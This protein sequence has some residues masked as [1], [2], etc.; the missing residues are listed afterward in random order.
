MLADRAADRKVTYGQPSISS[1]PERVTSDHALHGCIVQDQLYTL[2]KHVL[3]GIGH[4][5]NDW[6]LL[7]SPDN[8]ALETEL[9]ALTEAGFAGG[10]IDMVNVEDATRRLLGREGFEHYKRPGLV[11]MDSSRA[12]GEARNRLRHFVTDLKMD[13]DWRRIPVLLL[14]PEKEP[15]E[16]NAWYR[17]GVNTCAVRPSTYTAAVEFYRSVKTF[18]QEWVLLPEDG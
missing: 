2:D 15:E 1:L 18:W 10:C 4:M 6:V 9:G 8:S 16:V 12:S 13:E 11:I 14:I 3:S 17:I 7:V 5:Q